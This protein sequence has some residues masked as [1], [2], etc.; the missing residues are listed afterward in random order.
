MA[1]V[2]T[3]G[4]TVGCRDNS[5][6]IKKIF[7]ASYDGTITYTLANTTNI[8]TDFVAVSPAT[9]PDFHTFESE[10]EQGSFN[11]TGQFSTETGTAF[12]EQTVELTMFKVDAAR[13]NQILALGQGAWR[14]MILDQNGNYYLVGKENPV[15]VTAMNIGT[16]KAFS[17]L[18]GV[19]IT[20]TGKEPQPAH[21]VDATEALTHIVP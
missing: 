2:I 4:Y 10:V 5:G 9:V 20:F 16:G 3:S 18:N 7:I 8:I 17:D 6:G 15:R 13:R 14:I 21:L 11:Q 12:Y 19:T 1:C